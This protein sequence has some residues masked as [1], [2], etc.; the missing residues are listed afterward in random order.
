VNDAPLLMVV[1]DDPSILLLVDVMAERL[2]FRVKAVSNGL[3]AL[4]QLRDGLRPVVIL[5]D[6]MME[7][8]DGPTFVA[9]LRGMAGVEDTPVIAMS[10]ADVLERYGESL[11]V[12]GT[13]LKPITHQALTEALDRYRA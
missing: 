3:Q 8:I 9:H 10:T 13:L 1:D 5:L 7:R 12:A 2:G 6:I 11:P 4:E